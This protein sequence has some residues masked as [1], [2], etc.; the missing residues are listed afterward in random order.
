[1]TERWRETVANKA[2]TT[3]ANRIAH[4][5]GVSYHEGSGFDIQTGSVTIE[6]E[7]T[8][9]VQ[10]AIDRLRTVPG[11][12]YVALTNKD[13]VNVALRLAENT[14]IGVMDS[15]GRIVKECRETRTS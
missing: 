1:M 10:N 8:A 9:T 13:G 14:R 11:R 12:V 4:Y 3:T 6:V 7:T 2:H 5:Y 15:F